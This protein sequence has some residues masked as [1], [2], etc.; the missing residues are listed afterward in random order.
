MKISF[1]EWLSTVAQILLHLGYKC[2][3]C[4]LSWRALYDDDFSPFAAVSEN[5]F[6]G[7]L[8]WR[9]YRGMTNYKPLNTGREAD[10]K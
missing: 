4:P 1:T 10:K 8:T 6:D 3:L 5:E 2:I 7:N 9:Q